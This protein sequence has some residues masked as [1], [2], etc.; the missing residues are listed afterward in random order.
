MT[1][2]N[3]FRAQV[4][5]EIGD[6]TAV[7]HLNWNCVGHLVA[8]LGPEWDT[9]LDEAF[10][11]WD[12]ETIAA[13]TAAATGL[14]KQEIMD[15]S[16][17]WVTL[18]EAFNTAYYLFILG[19]P[20]PASQNEKEEEATETARPLDDGRPSRSWST[21]GMQRLKRIWTRKPSGRALSPK[22]QPTSAHAGA[23]S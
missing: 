16:P 22:P 1:L 11:K 14:D 10:R 7:I 2:A 18:R 23:Q 6:K 12:V 21:L 19:V 3:P 20:D 17:P 13:V 4:P 8:L 5:L 9:A 15:A